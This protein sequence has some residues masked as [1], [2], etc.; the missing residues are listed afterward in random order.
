MDDGKLVKILFRLFSDILDEIT[1]ETLWAKTIDESKG[2]YELDNITFYLPSI[3][4]GDTVFAEF[5]EDEEMLTYR[6]VVE[7]SGNSTVHIILLDDS[8]EI[9]SIRMTFETL[10]CASEK[11]HDKYFAMDVPVNVDY[12]TIKSVLQELENQETIS[13]CESCLSDE[14]RY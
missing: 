12:K 6:E 4:C 2:L 9:E 14:H 10:G 1:V 5:D 8:A 13:Y 3:A 11:L 7:Y